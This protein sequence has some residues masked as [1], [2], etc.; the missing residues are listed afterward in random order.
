MI[1]FNGL[2]LGM[3]MGIFFATIFRPS[4]KDW[5]AYKS[6][7]KDFI[8]D[9]GIDDIGKIIEGD[10]GQYIVLRMNLRKHHSIGWLKAA[11]MIRNFYWEQLIKD[12]DYSTIEGN[13]VRVS[14]R[15]KID[16][17]FLKEK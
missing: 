3:L 11:S 1:L 15:L 10:Y 17:S 8:D 12:N 6:S 13:S 16:P 5:I 2:V 9:N 14:V 4:H 7:P